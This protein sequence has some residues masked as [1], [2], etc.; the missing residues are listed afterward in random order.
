MWTWHKK[1]VHQL[2]S[3][4]EYSPGVKK[5]PTDLCKTNQRL[6]LTSCDWRTVA[7]LVVLTQVQVELLQIMNE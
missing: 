5:L 6:Q 4:T 7:G 2:M 1:A 3:V